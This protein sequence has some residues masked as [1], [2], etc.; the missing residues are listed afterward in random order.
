MEAAGQKAP[1]PKPILEINPTHPLLARLESLRD[2]DEFSD[3][4]LLLFEQATLADGGQLAEPAEFVR[5]LNRLLLAKASLE[6]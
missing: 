4:S 3:L 6:K 1:E 2:G 5:R